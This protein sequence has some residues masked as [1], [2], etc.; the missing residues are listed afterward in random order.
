M[1]GLVRLLYTFV[2]FAFNFS[3]SRLVW[4]GGKTDQS[5]GAEAVACTVLYVLRIINNSIAKM[6]HCLEYSDH[7]DLGCLIGSVLSRIK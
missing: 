2:F 5:G 4:H 3:L 1:S 6:V 7:A